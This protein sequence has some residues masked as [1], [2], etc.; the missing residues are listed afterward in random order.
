M[1]IVH[2][3]DNLL[4]GGIQHFAVS[5]LLEFAKLGHDVSMIVV[6]KYRDEYCKILEKRLLDS[7][8]KVFCL[9][10]L[11]S[12]KISLLISL[13][14]CR[15]IVKALEPDIINTHG[16]M[17]HFI[18]GF[19]SIGT[20]FS[21]CCTIHSAPEKWGRAIN[22]MC[23]KKPLIFCSKAALET[24]AQ[25]DKHSSMVVIANGISI[26]QDRFSTVVDLRKELSLKEKDKIIV[27]V[28]SLRFVKNYMFLKEIVDELKDPS[29][30]FCI[31][32]GHYDNKSYMDPSVFKNDSTIHL[33]GHRA[34]VKE[35]E[36]G[37]DL[38]LSCSKREGLPISV[39]EAYFNGI[40]CVL[41]PIIQHKYI[42][43][44]DYVWV[45][46][47]FTAKDFV[48]SIREAL[49]CS[50]SHEDIYEERKKQLKPFLISETAKKYIEFYRM[51]K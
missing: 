47:S 18:G 27:L 14:R 42:A 3:M 11:Y 36:N 34:D 30:H 22:W 32:G 24:R 1:K 17:S 4:G 45:P 41:S 23:S 50:K 48:K 33:L 2:I 21:Q 10:K 44:V 40:P 9:N 37:S 7:N 39:L 49:S 51:I 13:Y 8:I 15:K 28:G 25:K 19:A 26:A 20:A 31:C 12:N 43:D 29:I 5:L 38:L 46:D 6:E 35:I 16:G